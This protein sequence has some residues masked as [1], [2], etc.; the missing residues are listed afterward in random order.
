MCHENLCG[1]LETQLGGLV[2]CL[3]DEAAGK[4]AD[5]DN[6]GLLQ[7]CHVMHQACCA[8]PS[9]S[10]CHNGLFGERGRERG[11]GAV[12]LGECI[13]GEEGGEEELLAVG[14]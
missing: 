3:G 8:R 4:K 12:A 13:G 1:V 7:G 10:Q 11:G 2:A 6:S 9:V 5:G 14:D